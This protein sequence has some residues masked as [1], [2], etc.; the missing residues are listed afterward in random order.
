MAISTRTYSNQRGTAG[1]RIILDS[2]PAHGCDHEFKHGEKRD[3]HIAT[4]GPEDFG[5]TGITGRNDS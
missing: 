3:G 4:H 2:C 5:L 1:Q